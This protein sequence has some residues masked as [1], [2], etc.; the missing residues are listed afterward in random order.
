MVVMAGDG[1][2]DSIALG[3]SNIAIAMGNGIDVAIN[4][5]DIIIL[6]SSV[7]GILEAFKIGR[8][9]FKF[10]K[11]NLLISLLYNVITIPLAMLGYVIPLIAAIAMSLSSLIVVGNSMRIKSDS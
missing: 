2:N 1:I 10:I 9:T 7:N 3:K 5:S 11:E 6:D 8:K 4:I